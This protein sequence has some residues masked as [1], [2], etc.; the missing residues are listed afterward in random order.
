M[1]SR[2]WFEPMENLAAGIAARDG[3]SM[4]EAT[5]VAR[6]LLDLD[7]T[8]QSAFKTWWETGE[9]PGD[10]TA[11]G[12]TPQKLIDGGWCTTIPVAFTWMNGLVKRPDE[13]KWLMRQGRDYIRPSPTEWGTEDNAEDGSDQNN[14]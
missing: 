6:E 10:C 7:P 3:C 5:A 8:L 4:K 2:T 11:H 9:V 14:G 12:V 1:S 13:A